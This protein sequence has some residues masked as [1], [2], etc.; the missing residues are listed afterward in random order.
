MSARRMAL[1]KL[2]T[3]STRSGGGTCSMSRDLSWETLRSAA[4]T[5]PGER[6]AGRTLG[7]QRAAGRTLGA[8]TVDLA[9][10]PG[11]AQGRERVIRER[12]VVDHVGPRRRRPGQLRQIQPRL[13]FE[14]VCR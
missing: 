11:Q 2:G 13:L 9:E 10:Y 6:A 8:W 3:V 4:R 5:T 1:S 12:V 7:H 14:H